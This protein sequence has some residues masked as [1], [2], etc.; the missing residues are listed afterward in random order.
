[1]AA[2]PSGRDSQPPI[3]LPASSRKEDIH[4]TYKQ[5]CEAENEAYVGLTLFKNLWNECLPHI[6]ILTPRTDIC[7]KC[8]SFRQ[9]VSFTRTET[10]KVEAVTQFARHLETAKHKR[11]FYNN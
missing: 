5:S 10:E 1:M 8:E 4:N 11:D 6:K 9:M 7:H 2:A 3:Y